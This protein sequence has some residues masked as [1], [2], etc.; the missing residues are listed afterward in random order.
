MRK[1]GR[2]IVLAFGNQ[3]RNEVEMIQIVKRFGSLLTLQAWAAITAVA[4]VNSAC[5]ASGTEF[6]GKPPEF[7]TD[8]GVVTLCYPR[9]SIV[10]WIEELLD[11]IVAAAS[12][13]LIPAVPWR[14]EID[15]GALRLAADLSELQIDEVRIGGGASRIEVARPQPTR[16]A[17]FRIGGASH[18]TVDDHHADGIG[19]ELRWQ[20]PDFD[21]ATDRFEIEIA[22][23]VSD[24]EV[25]AR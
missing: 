8:A 22:G 17:R 2:G 13:H 7:R 18:L 3:R 11:E 4:V 21:G 1:T 20:S 5:A 14:I 6:Q 15:G 16:V 12:I 9:H 24:H 19:G 10:E 25:A 23:G